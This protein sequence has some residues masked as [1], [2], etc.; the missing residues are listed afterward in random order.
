MFMML[1]RFWKLPT[2]DRAAFSAGCQLLSVGVMLP[3]APRLLW[4]LHAHSDYLLA[5]WRNVMSSR[6]NQN[7]SAYLPIK[8]SI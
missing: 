8:L 5:P 6:L 3:G 7:R 2:H 1:G 4:H